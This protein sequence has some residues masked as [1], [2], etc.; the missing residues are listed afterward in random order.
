[1]P[2]IGDLFGKN[3]VLEQ[4]LLWGVVNQVISA[5][6]SPAF[7]A[8]QQDVQA[9]HPDVALTPS[10]MAQAAVR[11]LVSEANAQAEA[12]KSGVDA[13]RFATMTEL[14]R[15]RL[16]PEVLAQAV[17]RGL[18]TEA[19]AEAEAAPQGLTAA[20][21]SVVRQIGKVR[22][23]PAD[24]ATAVLRAYMT[25]A[26][27]EAEAAP[28][29]YTPEM[30]AVMSDLAGD[31]PG[32][33][34]LVIALMRGI[35][36][37]D[38]RGAASTSYAQGIAETRLHNKWGPVLRQLGHAVLSPSDAASAAIR[39]FL[40]DD[41]AA[42]AAAK[43]GVDEATFTT[44]RHLAGDAP[45][46]QQLAEALRR[47]AI[48]A[49]GTGPESTSFVQGIAE[50]R[51]A[52]KW[53]PTIK[54]LAKLWP[55]PVDA[56]IAVL[57]GQIP[58]AEGQALYERLGGESEFYPWLL[59]SQG[60]GPS[61]LEAIAMARRGII[62]W[63]GEGPEVVS[64]AQAFH[65]GRERDKWQ[66]PFKALSEY[67][68]SP[69]SVRTMLEQGAVTQDQA[70]GLWQKLGL[71]AATITAYLQTAAFN[72]TAKE[73]GLT[74]GAILDMFYG[75]LISETDAKALLDVFHVPAVNQSLLLAYSG[76]RRAIAAT[77]AAVT[78]VRNLF[79]NRKIDAATAQGALERLGI[80][81]ATIDGMLSAWKVEASISVKVLTVLQIQTAFTEGIITQDE[82]ETELEAIGYTPYDAWVLLSTAMKAALPNK[83]PRV[84][85]GPLG[86][87]TPGET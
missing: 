76:M 64:Y 5:L 83:P 77:Q 10:I 24:L 40:T 74:T 36:A 58:K 39:N 85:A 12:A 16:S 26:D 87:V 53:A 13:G 20:Q 2:G 25:E 54:A 46:P 6:A 47:G 69:D 68:P 52:D 70:I 48:P 82:G 49:E 38:G 37:A 42:A 1:M 60:E 67:L 81:T 14:A 63:T 86:A 61:T 27:A 59:D 44:L 18:M 72:D 56:L 21:W 29:G 66:E 15:V 33:D 34:Q 51:L 75:Q 7:T 79:T 45:G 57:K 28:Q 35:I 4:L 32:P 3:G 62:P 19:D 80:P 43:S 55:T 17:T 8:L 31:A 50:G 11:H 22:L 23:A 84:V 30:L 78:R 71:E 9:K 41:E 65:E 73:R